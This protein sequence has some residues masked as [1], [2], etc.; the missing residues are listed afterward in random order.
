MR[1]N[2]C[3]RR[4]MQHSCVRAF[5]KHF[6]I[7][8]LTS[9]SIVTP[10]TSK[11][12]NTQNKLQNLNQL[13][14]SEN[15]IIKW[16]TQITNYMRR[17][18]FES[19]LELF[20]SMPSRTVV[21]WNSMISGYLSNRRFRDAHQMFDEMPMRDL[22]SW[23][24]ML[25]GYVLYQN[26]ASAR[27]FF[28]KMPVRDIVSWNTMLSGYARGGFV[29]EARELFSRMPGKNSISWNGMISAYVQNGRVDEAAALFESRGGWELVSWN[30]LM[31]GYVKANRLVE[32]REIFDRM[33]DR[34][35]VSWN[36]MISA[37]A[38]NGQLSEAQ[39]LFMK[40]PSRDAFAWT[41]MVSGYIQNGR[42]DEARRVFD[43][44]PEKGVVS[45]NSII[46]GYVHNNRIDVARELFEAMP[47]RSISSW[48]TMISGYAQTDDIQEARNLFNKMPQRDSISWSAM[49]AGYAKSGHSEEALH[50]FAEMHRNGERSNRSVYTCVL[51]TCA[52]TG[53][54]E[55]GMQ[56]HGQVIKIGYGSATYVGNAL[57]AMYCKCGSIHKANCV[58]KGILEKDT[59]SWN[60]MIAGYARHG[61]GLQALAV[62]DTMTKF[63]IRADDTTMVAVLSACAHAGLIDRAKQY[64]YAMYSDYGVVPS[65]RHY[66]C[67]I[68][69]LGRAGSL[70]EAQHLI[71]NMPFSPDAATWG[72]LLGAAKVHGNIELAEKAA[73]NIFKME[74]DNS[75][76][77]VLLSNLY[78][79][80]GRWYDVRQMRLKMRDKGI[81]K[82]PGYSW[83]EVQNNIHTFAAG[84]TCHP[85]KDRI[86][87]FLEEL[88][89]RMKQD[90]YVSSI[91]LVLHDVDEEEKEHMLKYHSERLAVVYGILTLPKHKPIRV[92]KNLR[93]CEDCHTAIKH[94]SKLERRLIIVRDSNRFHHFKQGE[95]SCGDYW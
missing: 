3:W 18:H 88:E 39:S 53:V 74:P 29:D 87:S 85:E 56:I 38:Q 43:Q 89:S 24:L 67:M 50:L 65:P 90:G 81:K 30:C 16:N 86:Y 4:S 95:C 35:E 44:M 51:S 21:S 55:L 40:C 25:N 42:L 27:W 34:D 1:G 19:A 57:V 45:W 71:R 82:V 66:T 94:I 15:D 28:E 14:F 33:P 13:Q 76:M 79:A 91:K 46:A 47:T 6:S 10:P 20:N 37:Y 2:C 70:D 63:G 26:L 77:Y 64:F 84:D 62:F 54:L 32:A 23:N 12:F 31:G 73:E 52:D 59:V 93:I 36:T 11:N 49:I 22:F 72:A 68:D 92:M 80:S 48:N 75:G 60:T 83:L 41:A 8:S 9:T 69:L 61:F 7:S 78:A 58:F 17:G 5:R